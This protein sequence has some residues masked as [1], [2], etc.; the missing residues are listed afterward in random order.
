MPKLQNVGIKGIAVK[1]YCFKKGPF[2]G[3]PIT[4]KRFV[5]LQEGDYFYYVTMLGD[6]EIKRVVK[7]HP[8]DNKRG[9]TYEAVNYDLESQEFDLTGQHR[10]D[11][12]YI[13]A[14]IGEAWDYAAKMD[15]E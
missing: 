12:P 13:F 8:W 14:Y 7:Q 5:D 11:S 4:K 10:S 2:W 3:M 1:Q 6:V 15:C 9:K